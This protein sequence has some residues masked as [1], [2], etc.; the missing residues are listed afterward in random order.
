MA[1]PRRA[2][3]KRAQPAELTDDADASDYEEA[4]PPPKP[5]KRAAKKRGR[6]AAPDDDSDAS[7]AEARPK[8]AKR[9]R[10]GKKTQAGLE[11]L[12]DMPVDVIWLLAHKLLPIDIL[13]LSRTCKTLHGFF[14]SRN[15]EQCWN[16]AAKNVYEL[17]PLPA[18]LSWSAYAAFMF[19]TMCQGCGKG[20]CDA[21]I[22]DC[23]A[24][25]CKACKREN[26]ILHTTKHDR[27]CT[28]E[29]AL[30]DTNIPYPLNQMPLHCFVPV[31]DTEQSLFEREGITRHFRYNGNWDYS[32]TH[33]AK[34]RSAL[35]NMPTEKMY[36]YLEAKAKILRTQR[37]SA[38]LLV[39]FK[40]DNK[41]VRAGE[42]LH[43]QN[44]RYASIKEK[45]TDL[46]WG[47]EMALM[48]AK[49]L[50]SHPLV[51]Q[52][53]LL[54]D[55]IWNN[56]QTQLVAFMV[57]HQQDRLYRENKFLIRERLQKMLNVIADVAPHRDGDP[58]AF[59]IAIGISKVQ[60][61]L[62]LPPGTTVTEEDFGF[63]K[64]ELPAFVAKHRA[65]AIEHL[66]GLIRAKVKVAKSTDPLSLAV[67][68]K[69]RCTHCRSYL[70]YPKLLA[71]SCS[72][73]PKPVFDE[74]DH[75][76]ELTA[77]ILPC[78]VYAAS[79]FQDDV[80]ILQRI[81]K[82]CG[83][84]VSKATTAQLDASPARLMCAKHNDKGAVGVMAWRI[85][86]HHIRD[87]RAYNQCNLDD[88]R[89]VPE[90]QCAVARPLEDIAWA[91][92]E[93]MLA[94]RYIWRCT[95]CSEANKRKDEIIG[96]ITASHG[97]QVPGED[98]WKRAFDQDPEAIL[99]L[100]MTKREELTLDKKY[101][102]RLKKGTAIFTKL[103]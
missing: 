9:V 39:K 20:G 45:L 14:N 82:L 7:E 57:N 73:A 29:R 66:S 44:A 83:L 89:A 28:L 88:I 78:R 1:R 12:V 71:H 100:D 81:V 50:R 19:S 11:K 61:K 6:R 36:E 10:R 23:L 91:Q 58:S 74:R 38:P 15:S 96:H 79:D 60:E 42:R 99:L 80:D 86:Y 4:A 103:S 26:S 102:A 75:C 49:A 35:A 77:A 3:T 13:H 67:A 17:P 51:A 76:L 2:A 25:Y 94:T 43:N 98:D 68:T 65:D 62:R 56:I 55:R 46:G 31:M 21:M 27:L 54:T 22:W 84:D 5:A 40:E 72:N 24:R 70:Q 52:P 64:S 97:I 101:A 85:M 92:K 87:S 95:H 33:T 63:L 90:D 59:Q 8:P 34:L 37:E 41:A 16:V 32:K 53:K 18:G 47:E 69:F 93:D 30:P 48:P